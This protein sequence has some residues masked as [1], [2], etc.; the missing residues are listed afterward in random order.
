MRS[1]EEQVFHRFCGIRLLPS[2]G[3]HRPPVDGRSLFVQLGPRAIA[4]ND[5]TAFVKRLK[6]SKGVMLSRACEARDVD[7][8][9]RLFA[10]PHR[11][12]HAIERRLI[13]EV[14]EEIDIGERV[15]IP[16]RHG[17]NENRNPNTPLGAKS[18]A[19]FGEQPPVA[20]KVAKLSIGQPQ[21]SCA[22]APTPH[23]TQGHDAAERSL[24]SAKLDSELSD[25]VHVSQF[26]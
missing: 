26:I 7:L 1:V 23:R 17:A 14:Y 18:L 22:Q 20:A 11:E 16:S 4:V 3:T 12:S 6:P 15:V 5:H 19:Q 21:S 8:P 24:R 25:G 2:V 9:P 10:K 13:F